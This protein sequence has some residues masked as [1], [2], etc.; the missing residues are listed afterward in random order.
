[1]IYYRKTV[2]PI[3]FISATANGCE[4]FLIAKIKTGRLSPDEWLVAR[5][6]EVSLRTREGLWMQC[7]AASVAEYCVDYFAA[8]VAY[9]H[10]CLNDVQITV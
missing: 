7:K 2:R 5:A 1:M 4:R 10:R 6:S 9:R 8:N 3:L